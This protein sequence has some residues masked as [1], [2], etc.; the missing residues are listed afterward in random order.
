MLDGIIRF[1]GNHDDGNID[2]LIRKIL[3][4]LD[5]DEELVKLYEDT[6]TPVYPENPLVVPEIV[7]WPY[8]EIVPWP[9]PEYPLPGILPEQ[10]KGQRFFEE[11]YRIPSD[12]EMPK[13]DEEASELSRR[14]R[15][16]IDRLSN[17]D[18]QEERGNEKV[19]I[20]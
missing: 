11:S 20:K 10:N 7:P 13:A 8:P 4:D 16:A 18:D 12:Y 3:D 6:E 1:Y 19:Y 5:E 2:E 9:Y 15:E 17:N 14:I